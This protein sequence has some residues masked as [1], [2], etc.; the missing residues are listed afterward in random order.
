[1][2]KFLWHGRD[3]GRGIEG[4]LGSQCF[5]KCFPQTLQINLLEIPVWNLE[6]RMLYHTCWNV[7]DV[8]YRGLSQRP[9]CALDFNKRREEPSNKS[10]LNSWLPILFTIECSGLPFYQS[11]EIKQAHSEAVTCD[12]SIIS[13]K[14]CP[15]LGSS[16]GFSLLESG[17]G[18]HWNS[19]ILYWTGKLRGKK[20]SE[21]GNNKWFH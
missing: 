14:Y 8:I 11:N 3:G 12:V 5:F 17:L 2:P 18:T 10:H 20:D 21:E 6:N 13:M 16:V 7:L 15:Y 9:E 4:C 1:M 19:R